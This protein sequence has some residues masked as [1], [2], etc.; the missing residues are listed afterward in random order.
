MKEQDGIVIY[1][2]DIFFKDKTEAERL[3][4]ASTWCKCFGIGTHRTVVLPYFVQLF[5][6]QTR[7]QVQPIKNIK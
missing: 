2:F 6:Q 1:L 5:S 7:I 3:L 4:E